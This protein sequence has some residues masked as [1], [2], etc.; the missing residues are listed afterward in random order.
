MPGHGR[1]DAE[2]MPTGADI[3]TMHK[4]NHWHQFADRTFEQ[5]QSLGAPVF[6]VGLSGGADVALSVAERH[7]EVQGVAAAAPYLG[8]NLGHGPMLIFPAMRV[9]DK[10]SFGIVGH[11]LEKIPFGHNK[12]VENDPTPH[13][14]GSLG[15]AAAMQQVGARLK[16]IPCRVQIISTD[17]DKLSGSMLDKALLNK[18]NPYNSGWY[19][20]KTEEGVP[21]A[22]ISRHENKVP[23]AVEKVEELIFRFIDGGEITRRS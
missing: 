19:R 15:Q 9:L 8:G 14:Q 5:A 20:F 11:I 7:P 4:V 16:H 1:T 12:K 23:G 18:C 17:G 2:G 3:P 6:T 22:M 21:H 13:T 10:L